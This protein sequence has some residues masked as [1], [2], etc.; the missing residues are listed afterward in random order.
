M[1]KRCTTRP[2]GALLLAAMS[3]GG[4][5]CAADTPPLPEEFLEYLGSW[6]TDD[7]DWLVANAA[8]RSMAA[9]A[10]APAAAAPAQPTNAGRSGV[11]AP[12]TTERKP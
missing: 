6:E 12:V 8:A 9:Q 4:I 1:G 10:P 5:A 7:S 2:A 3:A 11:Q